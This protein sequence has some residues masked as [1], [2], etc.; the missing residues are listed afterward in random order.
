[1]RSAARPLA[2][3]WH[4][5]AYWLAGA[6]LAAALF[7][8]L[9]AM[10]EIGQYVGQRSQIDALPVARWAYILLLLA[11][12]QGAYGVQLALWPDWTS[13]WVVTL[14]WLAMAGL[15]AAALG[16]VVNS[17]ADATLLGSEGL[18]LAD[19][20]A[21]GKAALWCLA[22]TNVS[23][24]LAFLAGRLSTSWRRAEVMVQGG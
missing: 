16:V 14:A 19:K 24:L 1:V 22:M 17:G 5:A 4:S 9:P 10:V 18:Q 20:L 12:V 3:P 13:V 8:T 2:R 21:G 15:Y 7:G 6:T 11:V 23:I